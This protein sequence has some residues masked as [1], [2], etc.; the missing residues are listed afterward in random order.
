MDVT[1]RFTITVKGSSIALLQE[2]YLLSTDAFG[3]FHTIIGSEKPVDYKA[4]SFHQNNY[5]MK[6]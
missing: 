2:E 4:L 6:V 1:V 5:E 3:V